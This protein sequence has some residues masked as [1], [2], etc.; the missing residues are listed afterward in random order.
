MPFAKGDSRIHALDPRTR[1]AGVMLL[2]IPAALAQTMETACAALGI[3]TLLTLL[4]G[5]SLSR[6]GKRL[7]AINAFVL[8]LWLFLPFSLPGHTVWSFGPLHATVPGFRLALLLT[9]KTNA[10]SLMLMPLLGTIP[11]QTLGPAM[12]KMGVPPK[13]CHLLLFTY[14][15]IFVIHHEY[16]TMRRA[17]RAR[18]FHPRTD[19]HTYRSFA[20]LAG[21]L[22]VK[23][24]DRAERVNNAMRCRGFKGKFHSLA[25]FAFCRMDHAFGMLFALFSGAMIIM[26]IFYRGLAG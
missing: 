13:L 15:Y 4:A 10:I 25:E 3:G 18:G 21:M 1:L 16:R 9:I 22:L 6:V 2:S 8:F 17:M 19:M 24:W 23:S 5:L 7:L 20:W 14:R 26:E 11:V 12:Q